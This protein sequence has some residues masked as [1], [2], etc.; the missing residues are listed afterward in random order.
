MKDSIRQSH[1]GGM[2][3][4]SS[5]PPASADCSAPVLKKQRI[6]KEFSQCLDAIIDQT[7][8]LYNVGKATYGTYKSGFLMPSVTAS[9]P[10]PQLINLKPFKYMEPLQSISSA[11]AMIPPPTP[12]ETLISSI[13]HVPPPLPSL[14]HAPLPSSV[15]SPN[16][17]PLSPI[18]TSSPEHR[19]ER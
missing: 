9:E 19:T 2:S 4:L 1:V 8:L 15:L 16:P 11:S 5:V 6:A 18:V 12:A 10:F 7:E 3:A 17:F 14:P 13:E